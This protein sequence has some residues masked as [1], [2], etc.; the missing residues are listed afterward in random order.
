MLQHRVGGHTVVFQNQ[1]KIIASAA[2]VGPKE[3]RGPLGDLFDR[4]LD[5]PLC[6]QQ[7]YEQAER[8][9]FQEACELRNLGVVGELRHVHA[10]E[11]EFV[12]QEDTLLFVH[13]GLADL[14]L[15]EDVASTAVG[16]RL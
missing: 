5:D 7:S 6:G 15:D 9:L 13:L 4:V 14:R 12:T 1:P 11:I 10:G 16:R 3:G 2:V 8:A